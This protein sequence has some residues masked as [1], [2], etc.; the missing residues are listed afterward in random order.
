MN[1]S[2][3]LETVRNEVID[4]LQK[5]PSFSVMA[6]TT[7]DLSNID[8]VSVVFRYG[9]DEKPYK[10][11]PCIQVWNG[12]TG[13]GHANAIVEALTECQIDLNTLQFQSYDCA[14]CMSG[15]FKGC[16]KILSEKFKELFPGISDIPYLSCLSHRP[17][18]FVG[19]A[20]KEITLLQR[21]FR[22]CKCYM[23]FSP[24]G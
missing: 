14:T 22:C 10:R 3:H 7:A 16:Q 12:K 13:A 8:Q 17:N 24:R 15:V 11:L 21:S 6:D 2:S 18:T 20:V 4:Q 19:D 23:S 9:L 5:A 1:L